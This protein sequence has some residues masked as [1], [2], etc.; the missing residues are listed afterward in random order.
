METADRVIDAGVA[1]A[2]R[3]RLQA[4]EAMEE[5]ARRLRSADVSAKGE[6]VRRILE[7]V[8]GRINRVREAVGA[9][10]GRLDR[11]FHERVE[12][13]EKMI[14]EHPLPA[15]LI[16]AGVGALIGMLIARARD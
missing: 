3:V 14:T 8:E 5:A 7:D 15:V 10:Y 6:D 4:A 9:E 11:G 13:V 2:D 12:P 1:G 16:A